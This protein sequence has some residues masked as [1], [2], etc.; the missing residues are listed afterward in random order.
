MADGS[1]NLETTANTEHVQCE[2][3][4]TPS[5]SSDS[6]DDELI[7]LS[8]NNNKMKSCHSHLMTSPISF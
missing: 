7:E 1:S 8:G 2:K 3:T 4:D 6:E 5:F